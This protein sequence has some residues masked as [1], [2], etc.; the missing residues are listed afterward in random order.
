MGTAAVFSQFS[1]NNSLKNAKD[2]E[3]LQNSINYSKKLIEFCQKRLYFDKQLISHKKSSRKS[4]NFGPKIRIVRTVEPNPL[5]PEPKAGLL[6]E[7]VRTGTE[8]VLK[9][10]TG[11]EEF[12]NRPS[13]TIN[14]LCGLNW[15]VFQI[16]GKK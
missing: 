7:P 5:K 1:R 11:T 6:V 8:I 10:R 9:I 12:W 14:P 3:F 15:S 13:S 2:S 16:Q 4:K